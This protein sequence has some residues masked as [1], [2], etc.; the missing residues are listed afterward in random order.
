MHSMESLEQF[1]ERYR[2]GIEKMTDLAELD[3]FFGLPWMVI[4][5]DGTTSCH[6]SFEDLRRFTQTRFDSFAEDRLVRW[7]RRSFDAITLGASTNLVSINWEVAQ[8][9]GPLSR[10]WRHYYM[11]SKLPEGWKIV[12]ASFQPG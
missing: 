2:A 4:T 7:T 12:M 1:F 5:P 8:A 3:T 11:V 6:H 10:A 9:D